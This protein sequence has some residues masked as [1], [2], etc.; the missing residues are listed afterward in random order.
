MKKKWL[1][2]I[3]FIISAL[4]LM[5]FFISFGV[6]IYKYDD[7]KTSAPLYAYALM[8]MIE[9]ILPSIIV[10]IVGMIIKKKSCKNYSFL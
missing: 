9:F 5:C 6:D 2:K 10:F 1:Y 7:Y 4:L 8:R 3:L